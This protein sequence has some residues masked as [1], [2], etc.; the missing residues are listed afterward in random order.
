MWRDSA[1]SPPSA[2][3]RSRPL[4]YELSAPVTLYRRGDKGGT[5]SVSA[6][7]TVDISEGGLAAIFAEDLPL[8][9]A[10]EL[11]IEFAGSTRLV[12]SALIKYRTGFR[13]GFQFQGITDDDKKT[14]QQLFTVLRRYQ[15]GDFG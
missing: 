11:H 9:E 15:G 10:L 1:K 14:M 7:L 8:N 5:T 2:T 13:Y 12:L 3:L 6:G 4:R